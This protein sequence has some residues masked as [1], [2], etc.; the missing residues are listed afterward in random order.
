MLLVRLDLK[1]L[2]VLIV[3]LIL[4]AIDW[5]V[6]DRLGDGWLLGLHGR[7]GGC[8]CSS[9]IDVPRRRRWLGLDRI[10]WQ[11]FGSRGFGRR[12]VGWRLGRRRR[13]R[14]F[15]LGPPSLAL[16]TV[17]LALLSRALVPLL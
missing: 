7:L 12:M 14:P 9:C 15:T 4:L 6:T 5:L 3:S 17:A 10:G 11:V 8:P 1:L 16:Q 2:I 13:R